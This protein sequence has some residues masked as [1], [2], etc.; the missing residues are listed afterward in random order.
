MPR[1]NSAAI[2]RFSRRLREL[3]AEVQAGGIPVKTIARE[4]RQLAEGLER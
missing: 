2:N 4:L 3:I 1:A